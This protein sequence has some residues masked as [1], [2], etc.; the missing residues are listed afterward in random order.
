M[1]APNFLLSGPLCTVCSD[2]DRLL[3][4]RTI[5]HKYT[6]Y[7]IMYLTRTCGVIIFHVYV[8][9]GCPGSGLT[10]GTAGRR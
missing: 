2:F 6:T 1:R 5:Y 4:G 8:D 10:E 9:R 3:F 7:I